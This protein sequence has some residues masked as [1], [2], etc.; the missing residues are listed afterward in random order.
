LDKLEN[1]KV[2]NWVEDALNLLKGE[3]NVDRVC[4]LLCSGSQIDPRILIQAIQTD[5]AVDIGVCEVIEKIMHLC[6]RNSEA[7]HLSE[8][9]I[10]GKVYDGPIYNSMTHQAKTAALDIVKRRLTDLY[11]MSGR[12]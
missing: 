3:R 8:H 6:Q 7:V 4:Q 5:R 1:L 2:S 11:A 9:L 12:I 10:S